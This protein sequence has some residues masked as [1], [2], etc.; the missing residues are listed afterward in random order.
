LRWS[1]ALIG[2][3]LLISCGGGSEQAAS[4]PQASVSDASL[5]ADNDGGAYER[6][7]T[8]ARAIKGCAVAGIVTDPDP[9][10]LNVRAEPN[11]QSRVLGKLYSLIETDPLDPD[12]PPIEGDMAFGPGFSITAISGQWLRIADI[13]PV[14][15]G[16]DPAIRKQG[17]RR[18][19][20][21]TGW[22]HRS[23]IA[24]DPGFYNNAL[25]RTYEGPGDWEVIDKDAGNLLT[26]TGGKQGYTAP[27]LACERNWLKIRYIR[28]GQSR[29]GWFQMRPNYVPSLRCD[30]SDTDC[31]ARQNP[32]IWN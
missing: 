28:D 14:T 22:V 4:Q 15:T 23:K 24:V 1:G 21:G 16:Y 31:P 11:A 25:A 2:A 13:S 30:S 8:A 19:Y 10:G 26:F 18:N 7:R 17:K 29:E 27:L 5:A 9:A 20:Q 32:D 6:R 3:G 12:S